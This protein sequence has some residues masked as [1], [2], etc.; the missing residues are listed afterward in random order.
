MGFRPRF[1]LFIVQ[2]PFL[3]FSKVKPSTLKSLIVIV[4]LLSLSILETKSCED[5]LNLSYRCHGLTGTYLIGN[6]EGNL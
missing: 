6:G 1:Q 4:G 2:D 5:S 3:S